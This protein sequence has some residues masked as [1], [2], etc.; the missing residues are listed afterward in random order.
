MEITSA[1]CFLGR[2][3][4]AQGKALHSLFLIEK[5]KA[6]GSANG[7]LQGNSFNWEISHDYQYVKHTK[8][9]NTFTFVQKNTID[10]LAIS[11]KS[12]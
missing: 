9:I 7:I 11:E 1:D 3:G 8:T 2:R 12:T 10:V 4:K 5:I 6:Q